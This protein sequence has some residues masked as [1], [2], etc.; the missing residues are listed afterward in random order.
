MRDRLGACSDGYSFSATLGLD[1]TV[2]SGFP[3]LVYQTQATSFPGKVSRD[4]DSTTMPPLR[5]QDLVTAEDPQ[6]TY[7]RT[8]QFKKTTGVYVPDKPLP[9]CSNYIP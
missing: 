6:C 4:R 9:D 5:K 7:K 3:R 1:R 2:K 8:F